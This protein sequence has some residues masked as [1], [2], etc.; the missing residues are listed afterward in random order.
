MRFGGRRV[1]RGSK[2]VV[3]AADERSLRKSRPLG[4]LAD[5]DANHTHQ[6]YSR[7]LHGYNG[8][9]EYS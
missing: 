4:D 9:M 6:I 3:L 8:G 2:A 7:F 5:S 1:G